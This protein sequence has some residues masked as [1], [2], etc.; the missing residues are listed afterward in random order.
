[1]GRNTTISML[2][3]LQM[4]SVYQFTNVQMPLMIQTAQQMETTYAGVIRRLFICRT[5]P[6][7]ANCAVF[8]ILNT[9][10][11]DGCDHQG[12]LIQYSERTH[13]INL[14]F[15]FVT[16]EASVLN[17]HSV[18]SGSGR[19]ERVETRKRSICLTQTCRRQSLFIYRQ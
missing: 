8:Y 19:A 12:S 14:R 7:A 1:M 17:T 5:T 15:L 3:Q 13:K 11:Y 6:V 9:S 10:T 4:A 18:I 2:K 16:S